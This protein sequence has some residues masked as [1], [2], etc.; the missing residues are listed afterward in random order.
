MSE[1]SDELRHEANVLRRR[2]ALYDAMADNLAQGL[3]P[4]HGLTRRREV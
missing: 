2:A 3:V 4:I 1:R